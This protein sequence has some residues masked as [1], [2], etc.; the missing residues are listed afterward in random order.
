MRTRDKR[1]QDYFSK[2]VFPERHV[3]VI[4][5]G[6]NLN[7]INKELKFSYIEINTRLCKTIPQKIWDS[8]QAQSK[9]LYHRV[10]LASPS[11]LMMKQIIL[12]IID[13][14]NNKHKLE[15]NPMAYAFLIDGTR[16]KSLMD[17]H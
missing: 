17:I 7:E 9:D 16:I 2:R 14:V 8:Q 4:L 3:F 11:A 6:Q 10:D 13:E 5:D 12:E 15:K 1:F